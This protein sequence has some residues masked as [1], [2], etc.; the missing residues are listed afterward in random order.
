MPKTRVCAH[1]CALVLLA[2]LLLILPQRVAFAATHEYHISKNSPT[3]KCQTP[4]D[5]YIISGEGSGGAVAI[6]GG[7]QGNPIVVTLNGL[8]VNNRQGDHENAPVQVESGYC[9]IKL[10]G[11]NHLEGGWHDISLKNDVGIAGLRVCSGA[12]CVITSA[13]GDGKESGSL[14]AA[15]VHNDRGG[16]GIGSN[17]N[18]DTGTI[19]IRGGTIEAHGGHCGAGIGSGRDGVCTNVAI[20]GGKITA[21]GGEYAAGIGA[22]D[23]AGTGNGGNAN[24]IT[25]SGGVVCAYGGTNGGA[26]IGG[27]E[28]G[29]GGTITITG[30]NITARGCGRLGEIGDGCAAGIG[31]GDGGAATININQAEGKTLSIDALGGWCGRTGGAGIGSANCTARDISIGLCGGTIVAEGGE[32]GAGIGGGNKQSGAISISG[33]GT[34]VATAGRDACA[35]GAG[36]QCHAGSITINGSGASAA[37][38]GYPLTIEAHHGS[39]EEGGQDGALIGSGDGTSGNISINNAYV[40]LDAPG[41]ANLMGAG[42]GT[43]HSNDLSLKDG[44]IN[45][46]SVSNSRIAFSGGTSMMY[47]AGIGAGYGSNVSHI[48]LTNVFYDG[49]TIGS[50]SS[51]R[52]TTSENDIESI[53]ISGSTVTAT[54]N[55]R[56]DEPWAGIGTG[57]AGTLGSITITNSTVT[58]AGAHGGA[59]I[60]TA[61]LN[62]NENFPLKQLLTSSGKCGSVEIQ[63][64]GGTLHSVIATGSGG[65]AGIGGGVFTSVEGDITIRNVDVT[66]FGGHETSGGGAGIGGG[67]MCSCADILIENA[68]VTAT[69]GEGSAGIGSGGFCDPSVLTGLVGTTWNTTCGNVTIKSNS[70]VDATGGSGA[71]G[72]GLG[73]G[74]QQETGTSI[75]VDESVVAAIGGDGGAGIGAGREG[76]LGRGAEGRRI[77]LTGRSKVEAHGGIGA[78]GIGGGY[79]GGFEDCLI[80]LD[81]SYDSTIT[82]ELIP[83]SYV[84][85]YGG[86]GAAGIGAGASSRASSSKGTLDGAH[87]AKSINIH[88]GFV[89]AYG[90]GASD[91]TPEGRTGPG[92]GIGGGS[93]MGD[94][95]GFVVTGGVVVA[96]AGT[97][98]SGL[99][100][101]VAAEDIG[102]GGSRDGGGDGSDSIAIQGGTIDAHVSQNKLVRVSGGS[103]WHEFPEGG[104]HNYESQG[105]QPVYQTTFLVD[106][107]SLT[108]IP[109]EGQTFYKLEDLRTSA[110]YYSCDWVFARKVADDRAQVWLYLPTSE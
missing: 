89:A 99:S 83:R 49:P 96:R 50:S 66:A 82:G 37:S 7:D 17:Y 85:A 97:K 107:S 39:T 46:I 44:G 9:I 109:F 55:E 23:H 94:L 53:S 31:G 72:I 32:K 110:S 101:A 73:E 104:A 69:G 21:H 106:T 6:S 71:A 76:G 18:E 27:S 64:A 108:P 74:A 38:H 102:H 58:A 3:V 88:S 34:V 87:D 75:T 95:E 65:G 45:S 40:L 68:D 5:E 35:I 61:G 36:Q 84:K 1:A 51:T 90:G 80:E 20:E 13:A 43:G 78:A 12:T 29:D 25:I 62:F 42:I 28:G 98:H 16:A 19:I 24:Q 2:A 52:I 56:P 4:G 79:G 91:S 26:G 63:N 11:S 30:G 54:A 14:Y 41:N 93:Y 33:N 10:S 15:C 105:D 70:D 59:G 100:T 47:G 8:T 77:R 22:G 57:P 67:A 86:D 48:T 103:V 92:A 81:E 60:G